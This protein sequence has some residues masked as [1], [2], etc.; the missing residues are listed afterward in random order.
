[1][2]IRF[3][4]ACACILLPSSDARAAT[5]PAC[6]VRFS[7]AE[8]DVLGNINQGLSADGLK[9]YESK[10]AKKYP[11]VCYVDQ[12]E[13]SGIWLFISISSGPDDSAT[14]VTTSR[15]NTSTTTIQPG[16]G[17]YYTLKV[18]RMESGK[19]EVLRTFQRSKSSNTG[20]SVTGLIKSMQ[21]P[22]H[23]VISNAVQWLSNSIDAVT[24][25][26][27]H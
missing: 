16:V 2:Q 8:R 1:M 27:Q 13:P 5:K 9:W 11:N 10:L 23:D 6:L 12:K 4:L 26:T 21:N 24:M 22:E 3:L 19:P 20:G 18:T 14:A 25:P 17:S 7:V 15:G